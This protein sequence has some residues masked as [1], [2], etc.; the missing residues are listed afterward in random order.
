MKELQSIIGASGTPS[1][2]VE[3]IQAGFAGVPVWVPTRFDWHR[4][5]SYKVPVA[6]LS[7]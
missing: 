5:A 4:I 7:A 1:G 2:P 6:T 3:D